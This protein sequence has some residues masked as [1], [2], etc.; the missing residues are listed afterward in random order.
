MVGG[1][2]EVFK[3]THFSIS[4]L[5]VIGSVFPKATYI[6]SV[7]SILFI[8]F[9]FSITLYEFFSCAGYSGSKKEIGKPCSN[10]DMFAIF[11][12]IKNSFW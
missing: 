11:T 2:S 3:F 1:G 7:L 4:F 10:S 8:R 6:L 9:F 12:F 5:I